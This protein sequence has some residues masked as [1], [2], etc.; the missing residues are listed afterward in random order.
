MKLIKT[1]ARGGAV[2]LICAALSPIVSAATIG[3]AGSSFS[4]PGTINVSTPI[5]PNVSCG[6]T[7]SGVVSKD[8]TYAQI[9]SV[10]LTGGGLCGVPQITG[11]PWK[12]VA[13][14]TTTGNVANVGFSVLGVGCGP[15]TIN[16]SWSNETNT[17]SASDQP[18]AGSCTVNS[19]SVSPNPAFTVSQ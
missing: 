8:G 15:S 13:T 2:A 11:L 16:G 7:L 1:F 9:N 17:L 5:A 12:L 3:P 14:S 19:L 10:A 6:I 18:L 4:A